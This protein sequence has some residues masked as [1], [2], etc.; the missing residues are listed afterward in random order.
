MT[1]PPHKA[2]ERAGRERDTELNT[3]CSTPVLPFTPPLL[4]PRMRWVNSLAGT[5]PA[6][7]CTVFPHNSTI[8][9]DGGL[10]HHLSRMQRG[11]RTPM[12]IA[13]LSTTAKVWREP[14]CPSTDKCVKK[15]WYI[16]G[17]PGGLSRLSTDFGSGHDLTV[18]EFEPRVGLCADSSEPGACFR[19][20]VCLSL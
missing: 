2:V 1:G 11:T 4:F 6:Y 14:K 18:R 13:A 15:M 20:C 17:A 8:L 3:Q 7:T 10:H 19:F 12:F 9:R 16:Y 5:L